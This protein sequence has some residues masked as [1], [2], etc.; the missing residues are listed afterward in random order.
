[1]TKIDQI[2]TLIAAKVSEMS[3]FQREFFLTPDRDGMRVRAILAKAWMDGVISSAQKGSMT[4]ELEAVEA[5]IMTCQ[6]VLQAAEQQ[7]CSTGPASLAFLR[8]EQTRLFSE[9]Q[10]RDA[11]LTF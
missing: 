5:F 1:M 11:A 9:Q 2:K 4:A 10:Q 6:H 3:E 8:H 7:S